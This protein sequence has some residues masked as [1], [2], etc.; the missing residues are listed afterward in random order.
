MSPLGY[1]ESDTPVMFAIPLEARTSAGVSGSRL[2]ALESSGHVLYHEVIGQE[3]SLGRQPDPTR[4]TVPARISHSEHEANSSSKSVRP[5]YSL[6]DAALRSARA[7]VA[8]K[9]RI[10]EAERRE[11]ERKEAFRKRMG[12]LRGEAEGE[13]RLA[14]EAK[15]DTLAAEDAARSYAALEP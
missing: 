14:E 6:D 7:D 13:E 5:D 8:E 15:E 9:R 1:N 11:A 3:V 4:V 2:L 10:T 12:K